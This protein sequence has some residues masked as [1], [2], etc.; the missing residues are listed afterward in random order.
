VRFHR[1]G[2]KR[3]HHP[4]VGD[5]DLD[6]LAMDLAEQDD[7]RLMVYTAAP[8]T[9]SADG[10]AMLATWAATAEVTEAGPLLPGATA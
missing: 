9:P 10:L 3:L 8:G 1:E 2:S 4:V 5:L 7:L 6:Y